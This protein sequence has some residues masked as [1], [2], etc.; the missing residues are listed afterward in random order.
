MISFILSPSLLRVTCF[1]MFSG[2]VLPR[3][4]FGS[5]PGGCKQAARPGGEEARQIKVKERVFHATPQK[6]RFRSALRFVAA[7]AHARVTDAAAPA[8]ESF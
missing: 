4:E 5:S 2:P 1:S 3:A 7:A 6:C 8:A